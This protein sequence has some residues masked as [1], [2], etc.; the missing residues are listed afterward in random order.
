MGSLIS[1]PLPSKE[2]EK[3]IQKLVQ[4]KVDDKGIQQISSYFYLML[5]DDNE[6]LIHGPLTI[7]DKLFEEEGME[8][9]K[10]EIL[11]SIDENRTTIFYLAPNSKLKTIYLENSVFK[12]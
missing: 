5:D 7:N 3:Y 11:K 9:F 4:S 6:P 12:K 8:N 2:E 10:E 1:T